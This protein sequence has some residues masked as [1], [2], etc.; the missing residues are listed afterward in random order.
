LFGRVRE[1]RPKKTPLKPHRLS[2]CEKVSTTRGLFVAL[3][4][5]TGGYEWQEQWLDYLIIF[6]KHK[7]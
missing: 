2:G 1:K 7:M 4:V 6:K 3:W 5:I